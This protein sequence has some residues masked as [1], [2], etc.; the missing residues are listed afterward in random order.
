LHIF[1]Y[2]VHLNA[3]PV[4]FCPS[5]QRFFLAF[6]TIEKFH[7]ANLFEGLGGKT[8]IGH[9]HELFLNSNTCKYNKLFLD[10]LAVVQDNFQ[11]DEG[12]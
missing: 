6:Q 4:K 5:T 8:T 2:S 9:R 11:T 3:Y 7:N 12:I 10:H 1:G